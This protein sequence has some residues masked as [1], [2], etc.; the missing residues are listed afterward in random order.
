[1]KGILTGMKLTLSHLFERS[2]TQQYPKEKP[3]MHDTVLKMIRLNPDKW[4]VMC[5]GTGSKRVYHPSL[6][7]HV[8]EFCTACNGK[9]RKDEQEN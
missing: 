5:N 2:I 9:G 3:V 4:C 7:A 6:G 1:M 8:P